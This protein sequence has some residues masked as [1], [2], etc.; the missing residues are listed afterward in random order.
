MPAK[1]DFF[2]DALIALNREVSKHPDLVELLQKQEL[3]DMEVRLAEVAAYCGVALDGDY[4]PADIN[5]IAD[6]CTR[7]LMEKRTGIITTIV[8]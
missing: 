3:R 1:L 7:R 8:Q 2:S 4:Y 6:I 5:N